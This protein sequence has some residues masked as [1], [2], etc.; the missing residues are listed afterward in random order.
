VRAITLIVMN[1]TLNKMWMAEIRSHESYILVSNAAFIAGLKNHTVHSTTS[2]S[3]IDRGQNNNTY[4]E[5]I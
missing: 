2:S 1:N 4:L 3:W 5:F